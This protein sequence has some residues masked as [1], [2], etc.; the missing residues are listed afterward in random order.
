[1]KKLLFLLILCLVVFPIAAGAGLFE[2]YVI[3]VMDDPFEKDTLLLTLRKDTRYFRVKKELVK[4]SLFSGK[5]K[6]L[7]RQLLWKTVLI[8]FEQY[9]ESIDGRGVCRVNGIQF[10]D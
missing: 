5:F 10:V 3:D 8:K 6:F 9:T 4:S 1:M 7:N 2:G